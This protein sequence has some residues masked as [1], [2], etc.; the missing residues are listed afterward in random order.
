M[1]TL[2]PCRFCGSRAILSETDGE[3]LPGIFYQ[4]LCSGCP[5]MMVLSSRESVI[6]AWNRRAPSKPPDGGTRPEWD[7]FDE[8]RNSYILRCEVRRPDGQ[9][10]RQDWLVSRQIVELS[11]SAKKL[12]FDEAAPVLKNVIHLA[13]DGSGKE[14]A[15]PCRCGHEKEQHYITGTTAHMCG[16]ELYTA[17]GYVKCP[18]PKYEPVEV[19]PK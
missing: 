18:C 17:I 16:H 9:R 2:K 11:D 1:D 8:G 14:S 7:S 10:V 19:K 12:L 15:P 5:A 6:A 4:I 3:T 13:I